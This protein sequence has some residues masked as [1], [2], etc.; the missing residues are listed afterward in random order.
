MG[1]FDIKELSKNYPGSASA[2]LDRVSLS[3]PAGSI[4]GLL[5]PNGAGKT[6][7]ILI[8][9]GLLKR[10]DGEVHFESR[11]VSNDF[12]QIR[13]VT[14]FVPQELAFYPMLSVRENLDFYVSAF[15]VP[16]AECQN[17][18]D[19]AISATRL[20]SHLKKDARALSGGL[21]RRLNLAIGLLNTPEIL[22]LDEPTVGI[23]PQS[24]HFILETISHLNS[25]QNMTVIYTSHYMEEVEQLCDQIAIIDHGRILVHGELRE[26]LSSTQGQRLYFRTRPAIEDQAA[27]SLIE[28]FGI[29]QLDE[30]SY[31]ID[32][33]P[34][35]SAAEL[36]ATLSA[37]LEEQ[38]LVLDGFRYGGQT[39]EEL[40]LHHTQSGLRE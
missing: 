13:A 11:P 39:L 1:L 5:G 9:L 19:F 31:A 22:I 30:C 14:G 10:S 16:Q 25:E 38:G 37:S 35:R 27:K 18:M 32:S 4:F 12:E 23:D 7:L 28:G 26:L 40:Y 24:R 20:E 6:T 2:A 29:S 3:I 36:L 34:G 21:K 17:R 8:L 33:T 15:D